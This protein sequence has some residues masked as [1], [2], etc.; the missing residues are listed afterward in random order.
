MIPYGLGALIYAPLTKKLSYRVILSLPLALY[1][2]ASFFCASI[3]SIEH[4][5]VGRIAM[6]VA[7]ASAI[8][9]GLLIIGQLFEKNVRGRLVGLF[10]SCSFFA[11]I[12]GIILSGIADWRWLFYIPAVVGGITAAGIALLRTDLLSRIHGFDVNYANS[13]RNIKIR[14]LFIFIFAISF[15]YHGVHKWFGVYLGRIYNLDKLMISFF[16]IVMS[17]GGAF[18]QMIGGHLSDKKGRLSACVLGIVI[19]SG[20]TILLAWTYPVFVVCAILGLV[21]MGWTIGHN[22]ISTVLTDFPEEYRPEIAS[23]NSSVRFV[24]GGLG[25]L[26]SSLFVEKSF[27][28]TFL[29][30][31]ILMLS[32][33]PFLRKIIPK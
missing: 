5:Y 33:L 3:N 19:L 30:L 29:G 31:G 4:F 17:F 1:A 22:G 20:A 28:L 16:F 10:F 23:L 12:V 32:L 25:F 18:G 15:L 21:A 26:V 14:N 24:S 9:L 6:G 7:G 2:L 11:S 13:F 27:S 8:P